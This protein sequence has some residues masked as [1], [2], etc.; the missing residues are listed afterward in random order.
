MQIKA[1]MVALAGFLLLFLAACNPM[2]QLD[3][4]EE[5][6][7]E[8]HATYNKGDAQALHSLTSD[9][10]QEA[11]TAPQMEELVSLVES[12]M[13]QFESA[14]RSGFNINTENGVTETVVTIDST[15]ELGEAVETFTFLGTDEN[16]RLIGWHVDSVNFQ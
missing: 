4:S 1:T 9:E 7:A 3:K 8:W 12:R 14:E 15:Y 6:I 2:A 16:F 5:W 10:F 11:T 13:G